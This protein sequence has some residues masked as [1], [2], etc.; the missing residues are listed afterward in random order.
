MVDEPTTL[1]ATVTLGSGVSSAQSRGSSGERYQRLERLGAGAMGEVHLCR[2]TLMRRD[3]AMKTVPA[4][5]ADDAHLR[6]VLVREAQIQGDLEHPAIV[7]VHDLGTTTEGG[8]FFTM[9]RIEGTSLRTVLHRLRK[10]DP[11]FVARY[12][13]RRLLAAFST[14]CAAVAF[15]HSRGVLHR[16]IKPSNV[17]LGDF[18]EV[19][20]LDWG[21]AKARADRELVRLTTTGDLVGTIGYMAPEQARGETIDERAD[22]YALGALLFELLTL[23]PLHWRS[24]AAALESTLRGA[25]ARARVRAPERDVP[26]ELEAL[27]VRATALDPAERIASLRRM[28]EEIERFLDG[29]RDLERRRDLA[30][31]LAQRAR[32]ALLGA[33]R[34]GPGSEAVREQA[35]EDANRAFALDPAN[36]TAVHAVAA[37]VLL[38]EPTSDAVE[39]QREST[40]KVRRLLARTGLVMFV[41]WLGGLAAAALLGMRSPAA[42]LAAVLGTLLAAWFAWRRAHD[43][44]AAV[45]LGALVASNVAAVLTASAFGPFLVL[46]GFL[47]CVV[48]AF[49]VATLPRAAKLGEPRDFRTVA[50]ALAVVSLVLPLALELLGVLP[51]SIAFRDGAILILPRALA[52]PPRPTLA[53]LVVANAILVVVPALI[54][55]RVRDYATDVERRAFEAVSRFRQL[56]PRQTRSATIHPVE[57]AREVG[58]GE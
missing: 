28:H 11:A 10:G 15:A 20:L 31:E 24:S 26:P 57:I 3:V 29:D 49:T 9:R 5:L 32:S 8:A 34:G 14:V 12:G 25:D 45:T 53:I 43:E 13:R 38:T 48:V 46:P 42:V 41:P 21:V 30:E 7:P 58:P 44:S 50:L 1:R 16:D 36:P 33:M 39:A 22:V 27:C 2:D 23:E 4:N 18:G 35:I 54:V 47:A 56:L 55:I 52:F 6:A 19:Y 37:A 51:P 40:S 17:M